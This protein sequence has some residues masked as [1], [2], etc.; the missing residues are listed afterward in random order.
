MHSAEGFA[1][2]QKISID[3]GGNTEIAT[4]TA[5]GKAATQ[6]T[7]AASTTP[8]ATNIKLTA[9]ANVSAGDTLTISTGQRMER[10]VVASVGTAGPAGHRRHSDGA[11]QAASHLGRRCLGPGHRHFI[12]ACH[13]LCPSQR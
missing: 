13:A 11:A 2:G 3:L 10:A 5:V 1:V 4:V 6:T 7:L 8:G 12:H 9:L